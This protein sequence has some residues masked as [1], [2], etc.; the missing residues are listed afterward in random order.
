MSFFFVE[1]VE[2]E[3]KK[4]NCCPFERRKGKKNGISLSLFLSFSSFFFFLSYHV[5]LIDVGP[6]LEQEP[7]DRDVACYRRCWRD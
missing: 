3:R 1:E 4:S 7:D 2:V 5:A 6:L